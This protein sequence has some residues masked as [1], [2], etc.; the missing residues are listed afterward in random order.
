M[1]TII[2]HNK[3][4]HFRCSPE[5]PIATGSDPRLDLRLKVF[6][7][8][9]MVPLIRTASVLLHN[10][11]TFLSKIHLVQ[12]P[13]SPKEDSFEAVGVLE[14]NDHIRL[15][16]ICLIFEKLY[17]EASGILSQL[18][19]LTNLSVQVDAMNVYENLIRDS[20][21]TAFGYNGVSIKI[22]SFLHRGLILSADFLNPVVR[23]HIVE[24][25][26]L[27]GELLT[28]RDVV[29]HVIDF[30]RDRNRFIMERRKW[31][32]RIE[33]LTFLPNLLN[34]AYNAP[35]GWSMLVNL[36]Y[37]LG[38]HEPR[39]EIDRIMANPMYLMGEL[40]MPKRFNEALDILNR[41]IVN[42]ETEGYC[43]SDARISIE[44][45]KEAIEN[46]VSK[47]KSAQR[48]LKNKSYPKTEFY[49]GL[50]YEYETLRITV[51]HIKEILERFDASKHESRRQFIQVI[52]IVSEGLNGLFIP[53]HRSTVHGFG[54]D[55]DQD[56]VPLRNLLISLRNKAFEHPTT[57]RRKKL[58]RMLDI[59]DNRTVEIFRRLAEELVIVGQMIHHRVN[60]IG[61]IL[62][63]QDDWQR[64]AKFL[65]ER[66]S[67]NPP[68]C[69]EHGKPYNKATSVDKLK[70]QSQWQPH[71][72]P[73]FQALW[74]YFLYDEFDLSTIMRKQDS[75][76]QEQYR[77]AL[78][79]DRKSLTVTY[80]Y[81][82]DDLSLCIK[83]LKGFVGVSFL[84]KELVP[85]LEDNLN[86]LEARGLI[87]RLY[88]TL[89]GLMETPS[90]SKYNDKIDPRYEKIFQHCY[91]DLRNLR[92]SL[93]HDLWRSEDINR[94]V[95][96]ILRI[97]TLFDQILFNRSTNLKSKDDVTSL[98]IEVRNMIKSNQM[99]LAKLQ[100]YTSLYGLDVNFIDAKGHSLLYYAVQNGNDSVTRGLLELGANPHWLD[101][102]GETLLHYAVMRSNTKVSK[103][104]LEFGALA[105]TKD[106]DGQSVV[107][108]AILCNSR[109][110]LVSLLKTYDSMQRFHKADAL[111]DAVRRHNVRETLELL[112]KGYLPFVYDRKGEL[113]LI[114]AVDE[115]I[116]ST[117]SLRMS[118]LLLNNGAIVDQ[119]NFYDTRRALHYA[120]LSD[121]PRRVTLL[122]NHG[123]RPDLDKECSTISESVYSSVEILTTLLNAGA[124][125]SKIIAQ[126]P[127][128]KV[129]NSLVRDCY[130]KI[131]ALLDAGADPNECDEY[132]TVLHNVTERNGSIEAALAL[133][134]RGA[135]PFIKGWAG[136]YID[137]TPI[138]CA[139]SQLKPTLHHWTITQ[140]KER[141]LLLES[142]V[143]HLC[144]SNLW[145]QKL[146]SLH[147]GSA[148]CIDDEGKHLIALN[149]NSVRELCLVKKIGVSDVIGLSTSQ[150][151]DL[152]IENINEIVTILRDDV[153]ENVNRL[154]ECDI[155]LLSID[156]RHKIK[157]LNARIATTN[158]AIEV[159]RKACIE[160][161]RLDH[162]LTDAQLANHPSLLIKFKEAF[163]TLLTSK[164]NLLYEMSEILIQN[165]E[166]LREYMVEI[167]ESGQWLE[168]DK[169]KIPGMLKAYS[170]IKN[171]TI[172]IWELTT[173]PGEYD[174]RSNTVFRETQTVIH[175]VHMNHKNCGRYQ[176]LKEI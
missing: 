142:L 103:V 17:L 63:G 105:D 144:W 77:I 141:L 130:P 48:L 152:L 12:E 53:L 107:D 123:S 11:L 56:V 84:R 96:N 111:H 145:K 18:R 101:S 102:G 16:N 119:T 93:A 91:L 37:D 15:K 88:E 14:Q 55:P 126:S 79:C 82:W 98:R 3:G 5:S 30:D 26:F 162:G 87:N 81:T 50:L 128:V 19:L 109:K 154:V 168:G 70:E 139:M 146:L 65:F 85:K 114:Q 64:L 137:K 132:G 140:G 171:T 72:L 151:A 6:L 21:G 157:T 38:K 121:D 60:L 175:L 57:S 173:H 163:G 47:F 135:A 59:K 33:H 148:P 133:L 90:T 40:E 115:G 27:S 124:Q 120:A 95:N 83:A 76:L 136:M 8:P 32:N 167:I 75:D 67:S 34:G 94:L 28:F 129:A 66:Y 36:Y 89:R 41:H 10:Q 122:L 61:Q 80:E 52:S 97:T 42:F 147:S 45:A 164:R 170:V 51:A 134:H 68:L 73:T 29:Q 43:M 117:H 7:H 172:I 62:K 22:L 92:N 86:L 9:D 108:L 49:G 69:K 150:F 113:P 110:R 156:Q 143:N 54:I 13:T 127:L 23:D 158:K 125:P 58:D 1:L 78:E 4:R 46:N 138:D 153:I 106:R 25:I 166:I 99:T 35:K 174:L 104:L 118:K 161:Y 160:D 155:R 74:R 20:V 44:V 165:K 116:P 24:Q 100:L 39:D 112:V 176:P 149:E 131:I 71:A 2:K 169:H 31:L 159:Y